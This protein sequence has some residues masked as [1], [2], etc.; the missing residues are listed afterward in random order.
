MSKTCHMS[1]AKLKVV[2]D[3]DRCSVGPHGGTRYQIDKWVFDSRTGLTV[4][5]QH[6]IGYGLTLKE[7]R[8]RKKEIIEA[9]YG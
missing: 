2:I 7:A 1:V 9:Y 4:D 5:H 8:A 6:R 3:V